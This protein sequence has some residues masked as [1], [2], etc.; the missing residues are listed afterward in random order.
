MAPHGTSW[1]S[2]RCP[3]VHTPWCPQGTSWCPMVCPRGPPGALMTKNVDITFMSYTLHILV[4]HLPSTAKMQV[5]VATIFQF[6]S[7]CT[8]LLIHIAFP[9]CI[10]PYT[11]A[12]CI[13]TYSWHT[14][15]V[16]TWPHWSLVC[17]R[18]LC[19]GDILCGCHTR[20]Q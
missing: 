1:Y 7:T 2:P 5:E 8:P 13:H 10:H 17:L 19:C 18:V 12:C 6:S 9:I 4:L 16:W 20:L 3:M 15:F 14:S 11:H